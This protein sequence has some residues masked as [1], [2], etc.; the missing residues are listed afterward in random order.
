[1]DIGTSVEKDRGERNHD[2]IY[3]E[4]PHM[5]N[6]SLVPLDR[7]RVHNPALVIKIYKP[8]TPRARDVR[9]PFSSAMTPTRTISRINCTARM[10]ADIAPV[11]GFKKMSRP[12]RP[13]IATAAVTVA[14]ISTIMRA[15]MALTA[16]SWRFS[17]GW[18]VM[19]SSISMERFSVVLVELTGGSCLI[20]LVVAV[21]AAVILLIC[22]PTSAVAAVFLRRS[23]E[24]ER[25]ARVAS[26][27]G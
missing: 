19:S 4:K 23:E 14:K 13:R 5:V 12:A 2:Y 8:E 1:M 10:S 24:A 20:S 3:T 7:R 25:G 6:M 17:L 9:S 22:A 16:M 18:A 21:T 27:D 15:R 26:G 11:N